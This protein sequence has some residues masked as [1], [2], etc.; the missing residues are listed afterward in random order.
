MK[1][2]IVLSFV[3]VF[4]SIFPLFSYA[5]NSD[6]AQ[7]RIKIS[8]SAKD[9]RYF[10]CLP[11]VGCLSVRAAQ[12]GKIFPVFHSVK[13]QALFVTNLVDLRVHRIGMPSSCAV[14]VEPNQTLTIY[15]RI[16]NGSGNRVQVQQL[17][18]TVS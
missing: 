2:L 14:T 7:I 10:L 8:S 9:N 17:H 11:S 5:Y 1:K 3:S 6:A 12:Q 13:I 18:C 15:G 16:T 4:L